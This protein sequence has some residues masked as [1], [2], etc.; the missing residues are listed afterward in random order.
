VDGTLQVTHDK[1]ELKAQLGFLVGAFKATIER[2]IV[3]NLDDL[4]QA[5]PPAKAPKKTAAS[6]KK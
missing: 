6:R 4:L 3:K 1:F 2:E 5:T